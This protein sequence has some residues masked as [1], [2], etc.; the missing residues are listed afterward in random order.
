[1]KKSVLYFCEELFARARRN[2]FATVLLAALAVAGV[3]VGVVLYRMPSALW[4]QCNR[5][6]FAEKLLYG[7]FVAVL[8][9]LLLP[10]ALL[11]S[12]A[13][14]GLFGRWF[15]ALWY[16]AT[17]LC[18]LYVSAAICAIAQISVVTCLLYALLWAAEE[19]VC[20]LVLFVWCVDEQPCGFDPKSAMWCAKPVLCAYFVLFLAKIVLIFVV[21]RTI[22]GLI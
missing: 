2:G 17:F 16:V 10:S 1:M 18:G 7:G 3:V 9:G 13:V 4:W 20:C 14:V 5:Y 6:A 22:I 15:R 21:L 11:C 12:I 8:F 19:I